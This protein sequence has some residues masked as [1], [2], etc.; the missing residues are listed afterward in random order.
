[1]SRA[2]GG[3][4]T[5]P[6]GN[7]VVTGT[8]ISSTWGNTTLSDIATA[9][10]DSLSRSGLG[11]MT[12]PLL[13]ADGTAA[14]PAYSWTNEPSSGF[15]RIG[16][17]NI[18]LS[19]LNR[20]TW[21]MTS[22]GNMTIAAPSSGTVLALGG[23]AATATTGLSLTGSTTGLSQFVITST[24]GS[25]KLG[26][27]SSVGAAIAT[28]TSG[29]DSVLTTA[30]ATQLWLGTNGAG[31]LSIGTTGAVVI[32]APSSGTALS[33]TGSAAT[34]QAVIWDGPVGV[35]HNFKSNTASIGLIGDRNGV[36]GGTT[37]TLAVRSEGILTLASGGGSERISI[38]AAGNVTI[39]A[40]SSGV[41]LTLTGVSGSSPLT[42]NNSGATVASAVQLYEPLFS[43]AAVKTAA[44]YETGTFTGT[45]TGC[46]TSPTTTVNYTR[47]GNVV[48]LDFCGSGALIATSNTTACTITGLP[49]ALTPART[50][51]IMIGNMQDNS[52]AGL[53]GLIQISGTTLSLAI[54]AVSG[55]RVAPNGTGFTAAG[56]KGVSASTTLTYPLT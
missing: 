56:T 11:G 8:I 4:Y 18:G 10:T 46:T 32:V 43:A 31:R 12:A 37:G 55:A 45:L 30:N 5:L 28:G 51:S 29:Y 17:G 49:A 6:A 21:N 1:M 48:T 35:Y 52:V 42:V 53:I 44:T 14:L 9:L 33:V 20:L 54:C 36:T 40:P 7:P 23:I 15:Y 19:V 47:V 25:L 26:T 41:A 38:A 34:Q 2:A 22:A 3:T 24:A 27:E 16:A 13:I 39:N 50:E